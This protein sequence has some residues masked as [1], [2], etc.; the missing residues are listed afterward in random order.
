[1]TTGDKM[2]KVLFI[3]TYGDFLATFELPNIMLLQEIGYEV[4]CA[5]NFSA[6]EYNRKTN[7]LDEIGVI[8][9]NIEFE[10]HHSKLKISRIYKELLAVIRNENI[11]GY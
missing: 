9:H 11:R 2:K 3:S 4:H 5:S 6:I 10:D 7:K 1:M 8:R